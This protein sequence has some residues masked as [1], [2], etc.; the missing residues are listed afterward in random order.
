M[1]DSVA[2]LDRLLLDREPS[3]TER[4]K[5]NEQNRGEE[6]KREREREREMKKK[7]EGKENQVH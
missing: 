2:T 6:E 3:S 4:V 7:K 5:E 1:F